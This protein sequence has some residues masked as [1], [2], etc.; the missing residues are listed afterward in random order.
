MAKS[1]GIG[2][3]SFG[4]D[5]N[6]LENFETSEAINTDLEKSSPLVPSLSNPINT[7]GSVTNIERC[8]EKYDKVALNHLKAEIK[9]N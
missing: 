9:R 8:D 7:S 2:T 1:N 5:L 4:V 3:N 6:L